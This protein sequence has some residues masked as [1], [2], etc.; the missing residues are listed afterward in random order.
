[1]I[2]EVADLNLGV[3]CFV[4]VSSEAVVSERY[5]LQEIK[6]GT[7]AKRQAKGQKYAYLGL[8]EVP[9]R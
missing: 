9:L 2:I 5:L 4:D 7:L 6:I 1:M 8:H 3:S